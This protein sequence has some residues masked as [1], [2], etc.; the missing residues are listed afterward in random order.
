MVHHSDRETVIGSLGKF[1]LLKTGLLLGSMLVSRGVSTYI[2]A[3]AI[4]PP[5][6]FKFGVGFPNSI[7][8]ELKQREGRR[9]VV[10]ISHLHRY[11]VIIS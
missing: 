8:H 3:I 9:E 10:M 5:K 1:Y 7:R 2:W 11:N 6:I 4:H